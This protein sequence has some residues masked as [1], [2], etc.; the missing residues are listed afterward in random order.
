MRAYQLMGY[1]IRPESRDPVRTEKG[2]FM[3][4]RSPASSEMD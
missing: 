2:R 3:R 1:D 4:L